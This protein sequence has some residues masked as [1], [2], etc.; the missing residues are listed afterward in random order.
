MPSVP[1][2]WL[3][4]EFSPVRINGCLLPIMMLESRTGH[5][6]RTGQVVLLRFCDSPLGFNR[7]MS[8]GIGL[9]L[10]VHQVD[11]V[12]EGDVDVDQMEAPAWAEHLVNNGTV[13]ARVGA[14]HLQVAR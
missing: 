7:I 12:A 1:D 10:V 9:R 4:V 11:Q 2:Q 5:S 14:E 8:V 6:D 3:R 13:I